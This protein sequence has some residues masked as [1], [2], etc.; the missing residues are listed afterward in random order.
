[1]QLSDILALVVVF[2]KGMLT[3]EIVDAILKSNIIGVIIGTSLSLISGLIIKKNEGKNLYSQKIAEKRIEYYELLYDELKVLNKFLS[4]KEDLP[5]SCKIKKCDGYV[6]QLS[7]PEIFMSKMSF[8]TF[9][10]NLASVHSTSKIW[11]SN[12]IDLELSFL[13]DYFTAC[14]GIVNDMDDNSIKLMGVV[15]G[16]EI[17]DMFTNIE[18]M[19]RKELAEGTITKFRK[20]DY[21]RNLDERYVRNNNTILYKNFFKDRKWIGTFNICEGCLEI[22]NNQKCPVAD[23]I[24]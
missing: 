12:D 22:K 11:I 6:L 10:Q 15:L 14:W 18:N 21:K 23:M 5:K 24:I 20:T 19:I 9:M 13:G 3:M 8:N 7:I 2:L 16:T 4:T 1:M 17:E